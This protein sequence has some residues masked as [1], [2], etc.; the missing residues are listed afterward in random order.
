MLLNCPIVEHSRPGQTF[1]RKGFLPGQQATYHPTPFDDQATDED[2][3]GWRVKGCRK[4][5]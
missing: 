4:Q 5:R 2:N 1:G 3:G